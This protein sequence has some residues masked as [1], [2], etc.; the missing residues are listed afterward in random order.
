MPFL[1]PQVAILNA[2]SLFGETISVL[3]INPNE[4]TFSPTKVFMKMI[5]Q[6]E[7][8]LMGLD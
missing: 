1:T 5:G 4:N 3:I 2:E 7:V 8:G 6:G